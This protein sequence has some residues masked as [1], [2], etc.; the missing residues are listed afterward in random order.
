MNTL[1]LTLYCLTRTVYL[2]YYLEVC[3]VLFLLSLIYISFLVLIAWML[4]TQWNRSYNV[5]CNDCDLAAVC[6]LRQCSKVAGGR[7]ICA[8]YYSSCQQWMTYFLWIEQMV[9]MGTAQSYGA[10]SS[11]T[12]QIVNAL[13]PRLHLLSAGGAEDD[14][15]CFAIYGV[16]W[17]CCE[18]AGTSDSP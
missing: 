18:D 14:W 17:I 16:L 10:I 8:K 1:T 9:L 13:M 7:D 4:A 12:T 11:P 6:S 5:G 2:V 3:F 15:F